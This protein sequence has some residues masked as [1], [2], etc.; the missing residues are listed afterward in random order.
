[1]RSVILG[2]LG[3]AGAIALTACIS[4]TYSDPISAPTG[5]LAPA[6]GDPGVRVTVDD[7]DHMVEVVAGPF[8]VNPV[9]SG[10][11]EYEHGEHGETQDPAMWT[12]LIPFRWPVDRGLQGFRLAAWDAEGHPLPRNLLHHVIAVNF[13]RRQ[14]VYPIAERPFAFGTE[15]PDI[16]LPDFLELPLARGDSLGVYAMWNNE[17]GEILEGVTIHLRLYYAKEDDTEKILPFYVDTHDAIGGYDWFSLPPG[18]SEYSYE[19]EIPVGGGLLAAGGHLHDY[20]KELRLEEVQTG[21]VLVRLESKQD[22]EGHVLDVQRKVFRKL[23]NLFDARLRL[24]PGTRYRVV[25]EFDNPTADTIRDGGM[26]HMV[27]VFAPDD[28]TAWPP[29]DRGALEYAID[30]ESLPPLLGESRETPSVGAG[31]TEN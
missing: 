22:G 26:A 31:R 27:G 30:M 25:A 14:L 1:M 15:T 10:G 29:L 2:C 8:R 5:G 11:H 9:A 13:E 7:N 18:H 23:F 3:A 16:R 24:T 17:T 21:R 20:G 6:S 19:F 12:P 4:T 28:P